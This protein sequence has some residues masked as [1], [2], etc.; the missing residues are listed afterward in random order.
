MYLPAIA[1]VTL[2]AAAPFSTT[3][4]SSPASIL[5]RNPANDATTASCNTPGQLLC[6]GLTQWGLCTDTNS[7]IWM[8]TADG[9]SCDCSS[10]D[11]AIV[12]DD[13]LSA[14][15]GNTS[16][17][18][19]ASAPTQTSPP[20]YSTPASPPAD[21]TPT[22]SPAYSSPA[23]T[24]SS[25]AGPSPSGTGSGTGSHYT[26]FNGDG[27]PQDGWPTMSDWI[28]FD[29]LFTAY[30]PI[31]GQT[32]TSAFGVPNTPASALPVLQAALL[33]ESQAAGIPPE[34]ALAIMMQESLGCVFVDTT[35]NGVI[36]PGLF[37][38]HDGNATCYQQPTCP[39]AEIQ[40]MVQQG[41]SGTSSGAGLQQCATQAPGTGAQRY[42]QA[43][44]IYNSGSLPTDGNLGDALG[45]TSC[46]ASDIANRLIGWTSGVSQCT[47]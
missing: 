25:A 7:V 37:Q 13:D 21:S 24:S 34:F 31:M 39:P 14:P 42:Y 35:N 1:F 22:S 46:Y 19:S 44:R 29:D 47:L 6:N 2:A 45:S 8:A 4:H 20:A 3:T 28:S 10:G 33:S 40:A 23:S 41:V 32:C 27:S 9:T 38:D 15:S 11:C 12:N 17:S 18:I 5:V 16:A 36:N 43:A 26:Q 30:E